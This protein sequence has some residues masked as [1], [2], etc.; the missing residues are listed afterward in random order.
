MSDDSYFAAIPFEHDGNGGIVAGK[1]HETR[2][3]IAAKCMA[4]AM[5]ATKAGAIALARTNDPSSC[6]L[7]EPMILASYG[8]VAEQALE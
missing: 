1:P 5:V 2:S 7:G 3:E 6:E 8:E 4:A